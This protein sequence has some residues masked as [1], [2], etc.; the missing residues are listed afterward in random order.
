MQLDATGPS[1]PATTILC[2]EV[3][4]KYELV[5]RF[6]HDGVD[7][8][9]LVSDVESHFGLAL[10]WNDSSIGGLQRVCRRLDAGVRQQESRPND[11]RIAADVQQGHG[12]AIVQLNRDVDVT[13]ILGGDCIHLEVIIRCLGHKLCQWSL[14][15]C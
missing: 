1:I 6:C 10:Q 2:E 9:I 13:Q 12:L 7:R 8:E 14:N 5:N 3:N 15:N 4:A 11:R